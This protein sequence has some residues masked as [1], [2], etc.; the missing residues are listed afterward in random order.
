VNIRT[1]RPDGLSLL[2]ALELEAGILFRDIGMA[3]VAEHPPPSLDVAST[4]S[5]TNCIRFVPRP[6]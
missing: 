2:Q 3:D 1:A 4:T 5:S 6:R